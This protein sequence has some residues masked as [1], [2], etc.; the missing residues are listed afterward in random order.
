MRKLVTL[1]LFLLLSGV[2]N[3][4][5][6]KRFSTTY[7]CKETVS[8]P[9]A[10]NK[11]LQDNETFILSGKIAMIIPESFIN[12]SLTVHLSC[13]AGEHQKYGPFVE[14]TEISEAQL[15]TLRTGQTRNFLVSF[16]E[17]KYSTGY[18][19]MMGTFKGKLLK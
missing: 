19:F 10:W 14:I 5:P 7:L 1:L 13:H 2:S 17:N 9:Y 11:I 16:V 4:S 12:K 8:N 18:N 15:L 6:Q 3:A